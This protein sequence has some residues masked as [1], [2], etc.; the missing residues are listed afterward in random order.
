MSEP[1][2][3]YFY[4]SPGNLRSAL[5]GNYQTFAFREMQLCHRSLGKRRRRGA[6]GA[7][8]KSGWLQPPLGGHCRGAWDRPAASCAARLSAAQVHR[9]LAERV[10][11]AVDE[12]SN[13]L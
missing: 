5:D 1:N 11:P 8:L 3:A 12:P 10:Q 7:V 13:S 4:T 9:L 6:R 2:Q